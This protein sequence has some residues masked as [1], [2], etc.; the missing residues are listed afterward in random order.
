MSEGRAFYAKDPA[1]EKEHSPNPDRS[2]ERERERERAKLQKDVDLSQE[3]MSE[4]TK[5]TSIQ[6]NYYGILY[7]QKWKV[8]IFD[9]VHSVYF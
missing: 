3:G 4:K 6:L 2:W 1:C 7:E 8:A 5:R 9:L